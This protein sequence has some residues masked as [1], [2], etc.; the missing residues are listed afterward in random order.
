MWIRSRSCDRPARIPLR[1]Y[2]RYRRIA[3][4][5]CPGVGGFSCIAMTSASATAASA[6]RR[7]LFTKAR[8]C[9]TALSGSFLFAR[10]RFSKRGIFTELR[11]GTSASADGSSLWCVAAPEE[12]GGQAQAKEHNG[13]DQVFELG[14]VQ[15]SE[16]DGVADHGC[17]RGQEDYGRP[18]IAR[19]AV[20]K[21]GAD[22]RLSNGKDR[23]GAESIEDPSDEDDPANELREISRAGEDSGPNTKR[24]D[25]GRRSGKARMDFRELR[26]KQVV[27]RHR[28]KD[29]RSGED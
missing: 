15:Q 9:S 6:T 1:Q 21:H 19:D 25:G 27:F 10:Q 7:H 20:G 3:G 11:L 23:S 17:G 16:H 5:P 4:I 13:D 28:V 14:R 8:R 22:R 29:T 26:E 2:S 18:R 12:I 24:D